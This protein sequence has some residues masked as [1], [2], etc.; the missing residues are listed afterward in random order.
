M[1]VELASQPLSP[2]DPGDAAVHLAA[3]PER[4]RTHGLSLIFWLLEQRRGT[5]IALWI[6]T[7]APAALVSAGRWWV[8]AAALLAVPLLGILLPLFYLVYRSHRH[9]G[10]SAE[11]EP[12]LEWRDPQNAKRWRGKKIPITVAYEAYVAER[13]DF[14]QDISEVF[15]RRNKLF[16]F[17]F[18]WGDV[19]FYFRQFLRQNLTHTQS[20]D[21]GD[22]VPVYDRGNDFY[23]WFLGESM[24]YTS[25]VFRSVDES[26][27]VAQRRKLDLIC[28]YVQ[29]KPGDR[30]LDIGCGWGALLVHAARE[31]GTNSTGITLAREQADWARNLAEQ[32]GV[33]ERVRVLVD[34]Y[35][36]L[37]HA[38]YD[39][40]TCVEM[41]EHVGIKNFQRFLLQVRG[42]LK[43]DGVFY[44]QIAGLRRSWQF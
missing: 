41:A 22:I 43:D 3:H 9:D 13:L 17:C 42:L 6:A 24:V 36:N 11:W 8:F 20:S 25:G 32:Q 28:D 29:M 23:R 37:P 4:G 14:K 33:A 5:L 12:Y 2:S 40:I 39:K 34:D 44:L 10:G 1:T 7:A 30:H 21:R 15:L 35:R 26:L 18:T 38:R 31:R 27:E 19:K 16:R